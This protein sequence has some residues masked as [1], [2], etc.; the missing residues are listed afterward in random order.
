M[1]GGIKVIHEFGKINVKS[2]Q[3]A[4]LSP[5][6]SSSDCDDPA[7]KLRHKVPRAKKHYREH[8]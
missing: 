7:A 5:L 6:V 4:S 3:S 1:N 8:V 2:H